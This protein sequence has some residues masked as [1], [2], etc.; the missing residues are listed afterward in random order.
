MTEVSHEHFTVEKDGNSLI[1]DLGPNAIEIATKL[2]PRNR[3]YAVREQANTA[4]DI[5]G[6]IE[7]NRHRFDDREALNALIQSAA[8]SNK[9]EFSHSNFY[10]SGPLAVFRIAFRNL[11]ESHLELQKLSIVGMD[12]NI[13]GEYLGRSLVADYR[14]ITEET[15]FHFSNNLGIPA[16]PALSLLLPRFVGHGRAFE[17]I[18]SGKS[19]V[20]ERALELGLV[21]VVVPK[22]KLR[23]QCTQLVDDHAHIPVN[24]LNANRQ[25]LLA[26][27]S[28]FDA[29]AKSYDVAFRLAI[30]N[31]S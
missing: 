14:V 4:D 24:V 12:G 19:I 20:A 2:E 5:K 1:V 15:V 23:E 30:G 22:A 27:Y 21:S 8:E 17:L 7:I 29:A 10:F 3:Y 9:E 13:G 18:H 6:F 25:M 11:P 28:G 31:L 16:S 26:N